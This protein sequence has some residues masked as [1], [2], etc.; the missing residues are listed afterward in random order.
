MLAAAL[1]LVRISRA[2]Q[3]SPTSAT[4]P[5]LRRFIAHAGTRSVVAFA[6]HDESDKR[7]AQLLAHSSDQDEHAARLNATVYF[8]A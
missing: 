5:Y 3:S 1:A 7:G 8:G 2:P 4:R 6:N